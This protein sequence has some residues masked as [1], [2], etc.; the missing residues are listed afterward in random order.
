MELLLISITS[1]HSRTLNNLRDLR[2]TAAKDEMSVIDLIQDQLVGLN[3]ILAATIIKVGAAQSSQS[4]GVVLNSNF[5]PPKVVL[6]M[7]HKMTVRTN[8][9]T[10]L[11]RQLHDQQGL[12]DT[13]EELDK[14]SKRKFLYTSLWFASGVFIGFMFARQLRGGNKF[15]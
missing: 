5:N 9:M 10:E 8:E 7:L 14:Q 13:K 1:K 15:F 11:L 4:P 6:S 12:D 2:H 3:T